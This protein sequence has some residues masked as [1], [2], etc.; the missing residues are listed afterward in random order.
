MPISEHRTE[1][2]RMRT[3]Q[4][5]GEIRVAQEQDTGKVRFYGYPIVYDSETVIDSWEGRFREKFMYGAFRNDLAKRSDEV[6]W[7][8]DH[9]FDPSIGRKPL[10]PIDLLEDR[11]KG[12]YMEGTFTNRDF[13]LD[14]AES[15][16]DGATDGMSFKFS[17]NREDWDEAD[18]L[19]PLRTIK[20]AKLYEV[21][22]VTFPAY[23]ATT[24]GVRSQDAYIAWLIANDLPVP[25]SD[26]GSG[27]T[28]TSDDS[29]TGSSGIL[30]VVDRAELL[31]FVR[32]T[33]SHIK[34]ERTHG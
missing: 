17:V 25:D 27:T 5:N 8:Y 30:T 3:F 4:N 32:R 12:V 18:P 28:D 6:K 9:G 16:K 10:G 29:D 33:Q 7:L 24:A 20:E 34:G 15:V 14:I 22:V 21:S 1:L 13:A 31:E 11:K 2:Y 19:L 26:T 23:Q